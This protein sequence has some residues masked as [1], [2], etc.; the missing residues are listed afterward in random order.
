MAIKSYYKKKLAL[1]AGLISVILLGGCGSEEATS[2][3]TIESSRATFSVSV[4]AKGELRATNEVAL[5]APRSNR[6][7]LTLAWLVEENSL[8]KKGQVV[9]R[10][11]GEQHIIKRDKAQLSFDKNKLNS[12]DTTSE[13]AINESSI[14][15]QSKVLAEEIDMSDRFSTEDL[16]VYSKN[17]IIE[18]LLNKEYLQAKDEFLAWSMDSQSA[19]GNA[20][21]DL[22]RLKGKEFSDKV[23]MHQAALE[24]L[25]VIAPNDGIFVYEKNRRGD[26]VRAGQSLWSGSKIGSIPDLSDMKALIYV[27]ETQ[28]SGL[29]VGQIV[30]IKLDAYPTEQVAGKVAKIASIAASR[31]K[32][33][34]VKY[35]E[36]EVTIDKTLSDIMKPGQKLEASIAIAEIKDTLVVPNQVLYQKAGKFWLFVQSS[37]GFVKR[38]V[39]VGQRSLTKSQIISGIEVG[40][41]IALT[42]P[43]EVI[44]NE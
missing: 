22:L 2:T 25:E 37:K 5:S 18:Q 26:K 15:S 8:V 35:F 1:S 12:V 3:L 28:A 13:L 38:F 40:E 20:Q 23:T 36:I 16:A 32:D 7:S 34:P 17:E 42:K 24:N 6:G 9:A 39:E 33:N 4:P 30:H 11:D 14:K 27:L 10:F 21:L 29:K 43:T 31:E 41:H 44:D 19:Q